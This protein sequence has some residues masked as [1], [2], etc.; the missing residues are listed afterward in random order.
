MENEYPI[1]GIHILPPILE[2]Y[3]SK[4]EIIE[5]T[6]LCNT[7]QKAFLSNNVGIMC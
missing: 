6:N 2:L 4:G 1:S 3:I 5:K 7:K